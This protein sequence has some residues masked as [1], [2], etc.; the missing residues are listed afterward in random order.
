MIYH[1]YALYILRKKFQFA[2]WL[3]EL[4]EHI[5]NNN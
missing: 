1:K 3:F 5:K 4:A 2:V